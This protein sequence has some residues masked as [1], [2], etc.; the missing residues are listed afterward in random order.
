[1]GTNDSIEEDAS[2]QIRASL[3]AG[4]DSTESIRSRVL[5]CL[6]SEY[7]DDRAGM[8][9]TV[10]RLLADE[11]ARRADEMRNW[12][13]IT[14]CDRLDAAFEELNRRGIMARHN[15]TCCNTCGQAEMPDEFMR[16]DGQFEGV[17]IVG[18]TFYDFQDVDAAVDGGDIYL[19][20][21]STERAEDEAAYTKQC[22]RI[23]EIISEMLRQHG[24]T[25]MWDGTY[26]RKIGV[27]VKWQRRT[28]P[29]RFCGDSD[30]S[31]PEWAK[32]PPTTENS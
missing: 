26:A 2:R 8:G 18:Y 4:F 32:S 29:P 23:A 17:P 3:A 10:S 24:L 6:E 19:N 1:M 12:P 27:T 16:L 15:W 9:E 5:E 22:I 11:I 30:F 7:P 21:G 28:A 20:Y 14:D 31:G 25:V 13:Q